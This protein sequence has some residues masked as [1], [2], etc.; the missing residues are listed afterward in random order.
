MS[1]GNKIISKR[2]LTKEQRKEIEKNNKKQQKKR[3]TKQR[4]QAQAISRK[5][6]N[7]LRKIINPYYNSFRQFK[8]KHLLFVL[9]DTENMEQV[10]LLKNDVGCGNTLLTL[11]VI[12]QEMIDTYLKS[13]PEEES[14]SFDLSIID[15]QALKKFVNHYYSIDSDEIIDCPE[16]NMVIFRNCMLLDIQDNLMSINVR[17]YNVSTWFNGESTT[18]N[19][20]RIFEG[21]KLRTFFNF[22]DKLDKDIKKIY[23]FQDTLSQLL[24]YKSKMNKVAL[25]DVLSDH[26]MLAKKDYSPFI[27]S[28][29]VANPIDIAKRFIN[30]EKE[31]QE[32]EGR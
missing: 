26:E 20:R 2:N 17:P 7:S 14:T 30:E 29:L 4:K 3:K 8:N 23:I 13:L 6:R 16:A 19:G 24:L 32:L 27:N 5:H 11:P 28:L 25:E 9:K 1:K 12:N 18:K 21:K 22:S 15:N 10:L 31:T